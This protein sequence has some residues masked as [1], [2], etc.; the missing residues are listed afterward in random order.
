M[1]RARKPIIERRMD[2]PELKEY[3]R[4]VDKLAEA[5]KKLPGW[6]RNRSCPRCAAEWWEIPGTERMSE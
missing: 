6:M 2:T 4:A 5:A 3:W 1:K